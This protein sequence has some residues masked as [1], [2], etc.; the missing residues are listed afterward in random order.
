MKQDSNPFKIHS[1]HAAAGSA[2]ATAKDP[3]C[4]MDVDPAHAAGSLQ[5]EGQTYYFCSRHCLEKFRSVAAKTTVVA[6]ESKPAGSDAKQAFPAP[7]SGVTDT[8][9]MHPEIREVRRPG[10]TGPGSCPK[11]GMALEPLTAIPPKTRTIYTCP[12]HPQFVRD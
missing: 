2:S 12:M 5:H 6:S 8:C 11:C 9:P 10:Q 4:G 3:I 1:P 7:V